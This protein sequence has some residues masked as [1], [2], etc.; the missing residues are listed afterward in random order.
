[1]SR[2]RQSG[3]GGDTGPADQGGPQDGASVHPD[4]EAHMEVA[5]VA[6]SEPD[7]PSMDDPDSDGAVG[8]DLA[9]RELGATRIGEIE[10]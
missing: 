4:I 3:R 2:H 5:P 7:A 1:M 10:H 9:L 6:S 8:V